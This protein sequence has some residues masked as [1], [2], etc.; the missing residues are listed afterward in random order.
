MFRIALTLLCLALA[1]G[2]FPA[3]TSKAEDEVR[4]FLTRYRET[5]KKRD[6]AAVRKLYVSDGRFAFY[7]DG[8][9]RYKSVDKIVKALT[10]MPASL[11][12]K[13]TYTDTE[14]QSLGNR[15]A[16]VRTNFDSKI[17]NNGKQVYGWSGVTTM[18]LEKG[19]SG[20]Q[21]LSAHSSTPKPRPAPARS[22]S[23]R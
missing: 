15:I 4:A 19:D 12:W 23:K 20:W 21:V 22:D 1:P 17:F 14:V 3:K 16:L 2:V 13:S 5:I 18:V 11:D 10:G 6:E 9:L 7:E 8:Q